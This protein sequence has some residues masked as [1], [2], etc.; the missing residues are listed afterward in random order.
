MKILYIGL[1]LFALPVHARVTG[2]W[3][4]NSSLFYNGSG[5]LS[6]EV[7]IELIQKQKQLQLYKLINCS[8][9]DSVEKKYVFRLK[10]QQVYWKKELIGKMDE[11]N[12][13]IRILEEDQE[14]NLALI[15]SGD[16][17]DFSYRFKEFEDISLMEGIVNR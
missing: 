5:P 8:S 6:C 1:L 2:V 12:L 4:G 14:Y 15:A 7:Q 16:F 17:A 10:G 11:N 9:M 3:K 13:R